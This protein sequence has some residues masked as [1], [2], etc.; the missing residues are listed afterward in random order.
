MSYPPPSSPEPPQYGAPVPPS[1][2]PA[3]PGQPGY[4][5]P[6]YGQPLPPPK[7]SKAPMIIG[8]IAGVVVLICVVCAGGF[9][10]LADKA[11]DKV[12]EI[13]SSLGVTTGEKADSHTIRYEI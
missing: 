12:D 4:A 8:I 2:P 7:K 5:Q 11:S 6:G 3:P 9:Y 13:Q 1:F 10:F